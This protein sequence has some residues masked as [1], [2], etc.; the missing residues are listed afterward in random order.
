MTFAFED[1]NSKNL[2]LIV[3]L[4]LMLRDLLT[5]VRQIENLKLKLGNFEP[6]ALSRYLI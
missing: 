1:V 3:M 4:M 6:E 2:L 5:T